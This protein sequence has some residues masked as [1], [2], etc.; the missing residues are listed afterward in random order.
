MIDQPR[1]V[2]A[3][4]LRGVSE[5]PAKARCSPFLRTAGHSVRFDQTDRDGAQGLLELVLFGG[6]RG[7]IH[8]LVGDFEV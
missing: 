5:F 7:V 8:V 2:A 6:K 4:G 1:A 3:V